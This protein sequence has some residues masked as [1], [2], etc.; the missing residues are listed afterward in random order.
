VKQI[1]LPVCLLIVSVSA[2][3]TAAQPI[4][5]SMAEKKPNVILIYT[6]DQGSVDMNCYGAQDLITPH[7]DALARSGTR[8]TQFYSAAP[9]CSPSRA[10]VMTG[11]VPQRAGVPGNVSSTLGHEGMPTSQITIAEMMHAANYATGH[12]GKWHLGYTPETM[13]GGQG[14]DETFGHMGGCI[15]NYSHFFYWQGPNRHDL[16]HNGKEVWRDGKFFPELMVEQ[17]HAFIEANQKKPFFMYWAINL[18]HYPLQGT[19]KWREQY[20]H[21]PEPRR[22]YAAFISTM[23][24]AIG[25]LLSKLDELGLREN[26]IVILQSDHGHSQEER[27]FYGGGSAGPYRGAKFSLFEGGIRVPAIISWPRQLPEDQVRSQMAT[28]CDWMPTI[29]ELC[30]ITPPDH[31]IDGKSIVNA[32][33]D[34]DAI[35]PHSVFHWQS[36]G[37]K[38]NPQW[39]VRKGAWKLIGNPNDTSLTAPLTNNDKLFLVNLDEDV[40]EMNNLAQKHPQQVAELQR[41]HEEWIEEMR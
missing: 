20:A 38:Q 28:A 9:V 40:S 35:S 21:L 15:D 2:L 34:R 14:F 25:H 7:M 12:I 17:G 37:G 36:G 39:A 19:D 27:T 10:A 32:I 6:D 30:S 24:E 23:D 18:P 3:A 41:L 13:P 8:F 26:T 29:A 16:W 22:Q 5:A 4:D 31:P 11:R 1:A 33:H